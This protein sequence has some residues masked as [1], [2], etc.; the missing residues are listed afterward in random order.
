VK[1]LSRADPGA[2]TEGRAVTF[3]GVARPS[4]R[5]RHL[6]DKPSR[7]EAAT[8]AAWSRAVFPYA[9]PAR[10]QFTVNQDSPRVVI[11]F[12]HRIEMAYALQQKESRGELLP[13]A[14]RHLTAL[15]DRDADEGRFVVLPWSPDLVKAARDVLEQSWSPQESV[16][17]RTL[18]GIHLAA[19][20]AAGLPGIVTTDA[21]M[22]AAAAALG[23][24]IID[25]T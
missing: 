12:L 16:P 20:R 23:F 11:C 5:D 6:C 1:D 24:D 17:I 14:A 13:T 18:D 9:H 10:F 4:L 8:Q 15:F 3:T 21:R 19:A 2:E 7:P 25:P 22:R